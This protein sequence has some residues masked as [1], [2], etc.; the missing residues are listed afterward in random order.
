MSAKTNDFKTFFNLDKKKIIIMTNLIFDKTI[1][2]HNG[3]F[4]TY[5]SVENVKL[6]LSADHA[7]DGLG[8]RHPNSRVFVGGLLAAL[9][10]QIFDALVDVCHPLLLT[11]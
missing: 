9:L 1:C 5:S 3:I 11:R 7:D 6:G 4:R 10:Q 2:I 8:V